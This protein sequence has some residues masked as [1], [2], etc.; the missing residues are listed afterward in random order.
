MSGRSTGSRVRERVRAEVESRPL[1][2]NLSFCW[3]L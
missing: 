3:I 1:L 2:E